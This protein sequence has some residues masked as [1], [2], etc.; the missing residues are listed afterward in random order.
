M[1]PVFVSLDF[2][3]MIIMDIRDILGGDRSRCVTSKLTFPI[4]SD[5]RSH[6]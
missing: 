4:S 6:G 1:Y 5:P 2:K 3:I